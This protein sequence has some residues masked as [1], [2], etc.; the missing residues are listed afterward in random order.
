MKVKLEAMETVP[1]GTVTT[2]TLHLRDVHRGDAVRVVVEGG[3][4]FLKI[5][6]EM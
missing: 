1:V 6:K 5:T 4:T 2:E 3:R